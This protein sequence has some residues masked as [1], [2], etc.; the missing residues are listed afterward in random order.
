[1]KSRTIDFN[2][3]LTFLNVLVT[4]LAVVTFFHVSEAPYINSETIILSGILS[5]QTHVALAIERRRRD[6]FVILLAFVLILFF[7]L[8][9]AT[10][11]AYSYSL[12]FLRFPF[13]AADLNYALIFI[14][15]ANLFLYA[16]FYKVSLGKNR[17]V[18]SSNWSATSTRKAITL[19]LVT[20]ILDYPLAYLVNPTNIPRI[21]IFLQVFLVISTVVPMAFSYLYLFKKSMNRIQ[22]VAFISLITLELV[23]HTVTGSRSAILGLMQTIILV[24]LANV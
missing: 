24:I 5:I 10:L 4:I 23:L 13:T 8:R 11:A 6:P 16:G 17:K 9:V 1:M 14:I 18:E 21:I 3:I 19:L 12:V 7:S 2:L 20:I 22:I 15:I